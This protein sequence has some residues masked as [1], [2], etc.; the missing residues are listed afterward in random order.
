MIPPARTAATTAAEVQLAGLPRP[1]TRAG[2]DVSTA[3]AVAGT[4]VLTARAVAGTGT[5][6][7][8]APRDMTRTSAASPSASPPASGRGGLLRADLLSNSRDPFDQ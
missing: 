1:T 2:C 6:L 3:R 7:T 4:V 5:T 8:S